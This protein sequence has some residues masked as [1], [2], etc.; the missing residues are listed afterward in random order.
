VPD[1]QTVGDWLNVDPDAVSVDAVGHY[2]SGGALRTVTQG[3]PAPG[4]AGLGAY[5]LS[6]AAVSSDPRTGELAFLAGVQ[7]AAAGATLFAG[8]YGGDLTAVLSGR[9]FSAPTVSA[10]RTEA[11]VVRDGTSVVRVQAEGQPQLVSAPTLP[12]LG[13]A[14]VLRLSPDGVRAALVIQGPG[15]RS[16][17]IGTVVRSENGGVSLPD[18][19]EIAPDLSPVADVAWRDSDTLLVLAGDAGDDR[20][21][22][23]EVGVDGWGL[24][25]V[26]TSGLPSQ[27]TSIAAAPTRQPLASAG[28]TIWQL[29]GGTWVTLVRG[30]EPLPGTAPFYPL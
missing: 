7:S 30:Q 24:A 16:L 29:I 20:I 21:V 10:T 25:D 14:D 8:P 6:S 4:P 5:G 23:Y 2:L 9:S 22:P 26:S 11:W 28:D 1:R 17:Y 12:G 19:R 18:L 15:G 13:P 27:P 3:E